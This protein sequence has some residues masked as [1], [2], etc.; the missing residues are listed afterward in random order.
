MFQVVQRNTTRFATPTSRQMA[1]TYN[2]VVTIIHKRHTLINDI[3][4]PFYILDGI[5]LFQYAMLMMCKW[6]HC[7]PLHISSSLEIQHCSARVDNVIT[8][9]MRRYTITKKKNWLKNLTELIIH[10]INFIVSFHS[11]LH[12][13]VQ[14]GKVHE[15]TPMWSTNPP[16]GT[17]QRTA[18]TLGT[19]RPIYIQ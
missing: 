18:I 8:Y 1:F 2:T 13:S 9:N 15:V 4:V 11:F 7:L 3:S 17:T 19:S 16:E 10:W 5:I 12:T 6:L 14:G